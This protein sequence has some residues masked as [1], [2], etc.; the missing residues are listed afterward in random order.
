MSSRLDVVWYH[1]C[2][3]QCAEVT[4]SSARGH[5]QAMHGCTAEQ[6]LRSLTLLAE[7]VPRAINTWWQH[8]H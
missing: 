2:L 5:P 8:G 4:G 3:H 1:G 7:T 6:L